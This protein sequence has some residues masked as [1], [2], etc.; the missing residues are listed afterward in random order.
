MPDHSHMDRI[1]T[2]KKSN[3]IVWGQACWRCLETSSTD[4]K[5]FN[6]TTAEADN[7][8]PFFALQFTNVWWELLGSSVAIKWYFLIFTC[9]HIIWLLVMLAAFICVSHLF[10]KLKRPPVPQQQSSPSSLC[11]HLASLRLPHSPFY[12]ALWNSFT[13]LKRN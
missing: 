8:N 9:S 3:I 4:C 11:D 1:H 10:C 7:D 5:C 6:S 2:Y 13:P 12:P